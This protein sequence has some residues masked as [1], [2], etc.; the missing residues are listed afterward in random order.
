M[1]ASTFVCRGRLALFYQTGHT[2][3]MRHG[4]L[5]FLLVNCAD[6]QTRFRMKDQRSSDGGTETFINCIFLL[7]TRSNPAAVRR[8]H[9]KGLE[10][11][12]MKR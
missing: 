6:A 7:F 1:I 8:V 11:S 9:Q 5:L 4:F 3:F 10:K 2:P 12:T